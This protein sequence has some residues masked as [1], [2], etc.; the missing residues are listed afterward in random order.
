MEREDFDIVDILLDE[1]NT[2]PIVLTDEKGK[3]LTFEQVAVIPHEVNGESGLYAIL[4]PIDKIEG[5]KDDEAIV[6]RVD[7][8]EYGDTFLVV[9][10]D[11]LMALDIMDK[12]YDLLEERHAK[13]T[14]D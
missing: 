14:T 6:F 13:K 1:D 5:V 10:G 4:K 7:E 2:D 11:E 3:K 8:N 12:Y 9:E